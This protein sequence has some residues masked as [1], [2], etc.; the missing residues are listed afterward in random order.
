MKANQSYSFEVHAFNI[1]NGFPKIAGLSCYLHLYNQSGSH[2]TELTTLTVDHTFDYGFDVAGENF[3]SLG[4][5]YY[6]VQCNTSSLGGYNQGT[7]TITTDYSMNI[8]IIL[9]SLAVIFLFASIITDEELLIYLSG[10]F[11]LIGGIYTS[12][13]GFEG[14]DISNIYTMVIAFSFIGL[15][16]ILTIGAYI[17]NK[18]SNKNETETEEF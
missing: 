16:F 12:I 11:F 15:G 3:S 1:S 18:F 10:M 8:F 9:A 17:F 5:Y 13:Y 6:N 4:S 14:K 7:I 2:I